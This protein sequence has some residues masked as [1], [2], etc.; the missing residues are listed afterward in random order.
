[1]D[2]KAEL[3]KVLIPLAVSAVGAATTYAL[4]KLASLLDAKAAESKL[5]KALSALPHMAEAV[6]ADVHAALAP[7]IDAAAADGQFSPDELATLKADAVAALK[8]SLTAHGLPALKEAFGPLLDSVL[9]KVID[10]A[11]AKLTASSQALTSSVA[12]A[13]AASPK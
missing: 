11:Q 3:I 7:E 5:F 9:G 8:A 6:Y 10:S 1:M 2:I 4:A 12:P 13:P